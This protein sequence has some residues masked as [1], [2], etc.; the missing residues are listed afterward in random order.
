VE[1]QLVRKGSIGYRNV[2]K[3]VEKCLKKLDDL[4]KG[5]NGGKGSVL[6]GECEEILGVM[7]AATMK[8]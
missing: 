3:A 5:G 1:K 2:L 4:D 7:S 8:E 6:V